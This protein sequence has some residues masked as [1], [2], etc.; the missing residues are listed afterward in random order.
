MKC[1]SSP[2]Y[3]LPW[4]MKGY[5]TLWLSKV[6]KCLA[7]ELAIDR[8][9]E[10]WLNGVGHFLDRLQEPVNTITRVVGDNSI[11]SDD[12]SDMY[13]FDIRITNPRG[14]VHWLVRIFGS[15]IV[16]KI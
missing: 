15:K 8:I 11:I 5:S 9:M 16:E 7:I 1:T 10:Q 4:N 3:Y 2:Y 6:K 14:N 13:S 12:L